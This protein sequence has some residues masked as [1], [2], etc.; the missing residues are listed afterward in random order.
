MSGLESFALDSSVLLFNY[1]AGG[2]ERVRQVLKQGFLNEVTISETFYVICRTDGKEKAESYVEECAKT[3]RTIAPSDRLS[4]LAGSMKCKFSI[5]LAD[6]WVLA[7]GIAFKVP[8]LF[9]LRETEI[10]KKLDAISH[11]VEVKFLDEL[12]MG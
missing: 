3:A 10:L 2:S 6:C 12:A 4:R 1:F 9:G 8:C 5:S 11:D 7:T